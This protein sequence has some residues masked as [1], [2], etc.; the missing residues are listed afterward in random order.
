MGQGRNMIMLINNSTAACGFLLL[1]AF[2]CAYVDMCVCDMMS[3]L[4]GQVPNF[5]LNLPGDYSLQ[6]TGTGPLSIQ[7]FLKHYI[8]FV[9]YKTLLMAHSHRR[10]SSQ[11]KAM[12][13]IIFQVWMFVL[14]LFKLGYNK[15][16]HYLGCV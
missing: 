4:I 11:P 2:M 13:L 15:K 12:L 1:C 5:I 6:Y 14:Q 16:K 7:W 3:Y 8:K 9:S 10:S